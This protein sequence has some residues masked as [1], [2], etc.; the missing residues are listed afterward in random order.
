MWLSMIVIWLQ[1]LLS[2]SWLVHFWTPADR[3]IL[4]RPTSWKEIHLR[5]LNPFS[6]Y[7]NLQWQWGLEWSHQYS[8]SYSHH[9]P[10]AVLASWRMSQHPHHQRGVLWTF[11]CHRSQPRE[12]RRQPNSWLWTNGD[13]FFQ[14]VFETFKIEPSLVQVVFDIPSVDHWNPLNHL[15]FSKYLN[16][17]NHA[18]FFCLQC[19]NRQRC[20]VCSG[21]KICIWSQMR[22][23][24]TWQRSRVLAGTRY[25]RTRAC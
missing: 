2:G 10:H 21:R 6:F 25:C 8:H 11:R 17:G 14:C 7:I 5:N 23:R 20:K 12:R 13:G 24:V 16:S 3:E 22:N 18:F 1:V 9:S 15:I 19:R 4:R